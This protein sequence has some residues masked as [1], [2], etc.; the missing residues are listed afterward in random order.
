MARLTLFKRILI[1]TLLLSLLPLLASSLILFLNLES[2]SARLTSEIG[3][4]ADI[5]AAE[6]LQMRA[7]QVAENMADFLRQCESDLIFLSRSQLDQT[8]LLNFY[9][10]RKGEDWH[11]TGTASAPTEIREQI[12]LYR[13]IALIDRTGKEKLVVKDGLFVPEKDLKN[14]SDPSQTEFRTEEYFNR[15]L[16]Q[17]GRIYVSH[18]TGYHVSKPEQLNGADEP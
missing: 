16:K 3:G 6:S 7:S 15:V 5:Q 12:P 17:P 14:V 2:T 11:R 4:T 8:T 9:A 18:L 10:S 13:S 1:I